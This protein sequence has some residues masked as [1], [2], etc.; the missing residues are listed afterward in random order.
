MFTRPAGGSG[1]VP[2]PMGQDASLTLCE[3]GAGSGFM[4]PCFR[5]SASVVPVTSVHPQP[6]LY[7]AVDLNKPKQLATTVFCAWSMFTS[8]ILESGLIGATSSRYV[9]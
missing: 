5:N 3:A 7:K 8:M 6:S 4:N 9:I 2:S 1:E